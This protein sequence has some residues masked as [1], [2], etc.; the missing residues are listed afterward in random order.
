MFIEEV[1]YG[2]RKLDTKAW[3][4]IDPNLLMTYDDLTLFGGLDPAKERGPWWEALNRKFSDRQKKYFFR[5]Q[6]Q[7]VDLNTRA[8]IIIDTIHQ[9]KG[10][11]ADNVVL[12][13]YANFPTDF[14]GKK[15]RLKPNE[16]RVW[17]TGA[18]RSKQN[19]FLLGTKHKYSFPLARVYNQYMEMEHALQG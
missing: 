19:L 2:F 12:F 17:Y 1:A 4:D 6:N 7:N 5:M 10:G 14:D 15:T 13:A 8:N 11:E 18:T 16:A 3:R 9:V